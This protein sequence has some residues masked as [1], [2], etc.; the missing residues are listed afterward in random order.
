MDEIVIQI[1]K[2]CGLVTNSLNDIHG[3]CLP[4]E[5]FL[6]A[7]K[8]EEIKEDIKGLKKYLCSSSYTSLHKNA[9]LKQ[10]WP[11]L[12]LIRQLLKIYNYS[13]KPYKK[14]DGYSKDGKKLFRRF[15]IV[16]KINVEKT[17]DV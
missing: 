6:N 9:D 10:N 1:L 15:F 13:M 2:K 17:N 4:R 3:Q 12:N 16:E 7:T 8:Y 11:L 5:I 14:S